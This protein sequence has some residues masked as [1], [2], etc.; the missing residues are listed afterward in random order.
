MAD[1]PTRDT[2]RR[3]AY[4]VGHPPRIPPLAPEQYSDDV[5]ETTRALR[6]AVGLPADGA[7]SDFVATGLRHPT[8]FK[9]NID[10]AIQLVG[11]GTLPARDRELAILRTAWLCQAPF[12]WGEH[13]GIGRR[14]GLTGDEIER[15][16]QGAGAPGWSDDDSILLRAVE[17]LHADAM[18]G[19]ETWGRLAARLT[20]QQLIELPLL[21]GQY[22]GVAFLQN[23]L[24]S[25]LMPGNSG[26]GQR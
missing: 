20:E 25:P 18:I 15:V 4:I 21:V 11:H 24:R 23:S 22:I 17:E 9:A 5:R 19:D 8:L 7:L 3:D 16:T 10:Y 1:P 6:I 12:E 2:D 14:V 26:L 13:V